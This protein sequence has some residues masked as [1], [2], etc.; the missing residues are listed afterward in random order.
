MT[1]SVTFEQAL[2][3]LEEIVKRLQQPDVPLDE[4]IALYK[5]GTELA[6]R[7]EELLSSAEIQVQQL[8]SA[9][10]ERFARY[11]FDEDAEQDLPE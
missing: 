11:T 3:E 6:Q 7:S 9:V 8:T 10:Q 1:G 2:A 5:R 4:A